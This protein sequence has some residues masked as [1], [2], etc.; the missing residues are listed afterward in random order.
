MLAL[1]LAGFAGNARALVAIPVP[2]SG[3]NNGTRWGPTTADI[4]RDRC[5]AFAVEFEGGKKQEMVVTVE[6]SNDAL[7]YVAM[8]I[9]R[10]NNLEVAGYPAILEFCATSIQQP[11]PTRA[12]MRFDAGGPGASEARCWGEF[13]DSV[14][15]AGYY[16]GGNERDT[17]RPNCQDWT[18]PIK[19]EGAGADGKSS[20]YKLK[21]LAS[22]SDGCK[23]QDGT[24]YVYVYANR[25]T[26]VTVTIDQVDTGSKCSD[27]KA[28]NRAAAI[29]LAVLVSLCLCCCCAGA[30]CYDKHQKKQQQMHLNNPAYGEAAP[31][32]GTVMSVEPPPVYGQAAM[33]KPPAYGAPPAGTGGPIQGSVVAPPPAYDAPPAYGV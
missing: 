22:D 33:D 9:G 10:Y 17:K 28:N 14:D 30:V 26:T 25:D 27:N 21:V 32:T 3:A 31:G 4:S 8:G 5:R 15:T 18:Q 19:L 16:Y 1:V 13:Y 11:P 23:T 29:L 7:N 2:K 6:D 24:Y 12:R 20:P